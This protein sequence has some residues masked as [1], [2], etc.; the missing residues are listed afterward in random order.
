M[1]IATI[2]GFVMGLGAIIGGAALEGLH[3]TAL[4]QPTAA[5]IVLGGTFG[6]AFI[7]FP[8][9]AVIG[10]FKDLKKL[11]AS[12]PSNA[13]LIVEFC[14]YAAKARKIGRAHV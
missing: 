3:L 14:G 6:A 13:D 1:D 12:S 4:I 5:M 7:S 2:I 10:A 9:H 8:L 11:L